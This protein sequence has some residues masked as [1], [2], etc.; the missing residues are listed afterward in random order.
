MKTITL[1]KTVVVAGLEVAALFALAYIM[2][3]HSIV[4]MHTQ[5]LH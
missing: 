5:L 2:Y 1:F 4:G 3:V